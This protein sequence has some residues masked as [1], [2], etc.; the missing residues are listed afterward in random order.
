MTDQLLDAPGCRPSR[1]RTCLAAILPDIA[2]DEDRAFYRDLLLFGLILFGSTLAVYL[3]TTRWQLP[4]PQDNTTLVF[5]RDFLNFWMYG[6]AAVMPDPGRFYDVDTYNQALLALLGP[7]FPGQNWSYPPSIMLI[8]L[9]FGQLG[10]LTALACWTV[11]GV[12]LFLW[13]AKDHVR[14]L[15]TLLLVL[16]S[17][18]ALFCLISG[19]SSFITAA[20]LL[21]I[22]AWLDRRPWAAG[23]LIGLLTMKPQLGLLFPFMLAAS[24]RW[25]VFAVAALTA[26]ALVAVTSVTFGP[27]VWIDFITLGLPAQN[28]VLADPNLVATP[29]YPTVF[30]NIRGLDTSYAVAMAVQL[31]FSLGAVAVVSWAFAFRRDGD[32]ALLRAVFFA[33]TVAASPYLLAYDILPLTVAAVALLVHGGLDVPGRRLAQLVFWL[34]SLQLAFGIGHV[35]GPA[36]IAPAFAV[37][38]VLR[39]KGRP[40]PAAVPA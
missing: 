20:M 27:K 6:R 15:R 31:P 14:D 34:P 37:Y 38:L 39:L 8:A 23:I 10:Y 16:I 36:L 11:L 24:G 4:F 29:F 40:A 22:F 32:P 33:C 35:P 2:R 30:M 9:P 1:W 19:Q 21:L 13:V 12:G 7:G 5:G 25:R 3:F 28:L 18:A 17:P 26:T